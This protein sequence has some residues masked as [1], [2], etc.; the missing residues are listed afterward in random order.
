MTDNTQIYA[1][2]PY[3]KLVDKNYSK[4]LIVS[5]LQEKCL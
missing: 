1:N 4:L 5:L 2:K 3:K